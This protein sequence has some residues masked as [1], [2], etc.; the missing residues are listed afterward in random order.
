MSTNNSEDGGIVFPVVDC[1]N[2]SQW[3]PDRSSQKGRA[4]GWRG[5]SPGVLG[6]EEREKGTEGERKADLAGPG[7]EFFRVIVKI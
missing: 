5:W 2:Q 1:N 4:T 6:Q 7:N 3:E